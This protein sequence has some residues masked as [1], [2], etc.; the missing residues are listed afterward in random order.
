MVSEAAVS[1][2]R[3]DA[4][5]V[6]NVDGDL[7]ARIPLET[8]QGMSSLD[9]ENYP[10]LGSERG[11]LYAVSLDEPPI[12]GEVVVSLVNPAG[13]QITTAQLRFN[14]YSEDGSLP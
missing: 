12:H 6:R 5:N 3:F 11:E 13:E 7:I 14:C 1:N 8:N 9:P 2:Q 4:I 10:V